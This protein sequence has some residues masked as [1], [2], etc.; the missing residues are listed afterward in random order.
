LVA[1]F[2]TLLAAGMGAWVTAAAMPRGSSRLVGRNLPIDPGATDPLDISAH[3]S[4]AVAANP[5]NQANLV[6]A[7][8]IDTPQFSCGLHISVDGGVNWR[9][10]P[11]PLPSGKVVACMSPDI[12]FGSD[13]RL[14]VAFASFAKV[15]RLGTVPDALWVS[16]SDDGGRNLSSPV[17]A[18]GPSVFH[19]RVLADRAVA[20]RVFVTWVRASETGPYG[21]LTTGNPVVISRSD[22]GGA[23]WSQP[24]TASDPSRARVVSPVLA[25]GRRGQLFLAYLDVG[26]D[27][28]D[29]EGA[30]QNNGGDP[31]AGRWSLAV[32][33]SIDNGKTWS[34]T[35]V[36]AGL[37]PTARFRMLFPLAPALAVDLR[38]GRVYLALQDGRGGDADVWL[39][40]SKDGRHWPRPARVNDTRRRDGRAQYLPALSVA[41]DG[42]LDVIYYD[43]R[44]DAGNA[45][46]EVSLQ[47]SSDGGHSFSPRL[48]LSDRPFDSTVGYGRNT[49]LPELGNRLGLLSTVRGSF[50]VWS[51]T[52]AGDQFSGKQ[53]LARELVSFSPPSRLRGPLQFISVVMIAIGVC[54]LA[55]M[56]VSRRRG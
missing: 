45:K 41:S 12:S 14:Y 32:A 54:G 15:E 50:A 46:N 1:I 55:F 18:A 28:L 49:G 47:T 23:T 35:T 7:D 5:A 37:V 24:V 26:D 43:R 16:T 20:G 13:G 30:H 44:D 3:N 25:A 56:V 21:L 9:L 17:Q 31:Y 29:Y 4:P 8:R 42:R 48:R 33:R 10:T 38:N 34:D 40:R 6:I 39:W 27:R 11:I 2:L 51:D 19:A 22:N 36:D 53:N 52:R